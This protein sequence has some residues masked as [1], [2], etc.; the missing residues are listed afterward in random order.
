VKVLTGI[1]IINPAGYT[2]AFSM[3]NRPWTRDPKIQHIN[4]VPATGSLLMKA[5]PGYSMPPHQEVDYVH[6][7]VETLLFLENYITI[8][9]R[10]IYKISTG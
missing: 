3:D 7:G 10:R 2:M 8:P 9:I 6:S 1:W 4:T 5:I